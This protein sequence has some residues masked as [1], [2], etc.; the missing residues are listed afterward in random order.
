MA[1]NSDLNVF[2]MIWFVSEI[3]NKLPNGLFVTDVCKT[4]KPLTILLTMSLLTIL[5]GTNYNTVISR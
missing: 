3:S 4:L 1:W 5:Q 2:K